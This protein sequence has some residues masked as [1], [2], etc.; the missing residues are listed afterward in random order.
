MVCREMEK[1]TAL[2]P[3]GEECRTVVPRLVEICAGESA[4]HSMEECREPAGSYENIRGS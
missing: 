2:P 1:A 3:L 4:W